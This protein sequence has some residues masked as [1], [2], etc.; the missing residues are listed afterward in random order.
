MTQGRKKVIGVIGASACSQDAVTIAERVGEEIAGRGALLV[1]GGRGGVM[2]AACRGAKNRGGTT[3]GI[4]PDS[5]SGTAN[6]YVDI[7]I[8]TGLGEARNS[9][10]VNSADGLIAVSGSYGTLSEIAFALKQGKPVVGI[11]TWDIDEKIEK[12]QDAA[13]AVNLIFERIVSAN[14]SRS[15]NHGR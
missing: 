15:S 3:I 12:A 14:Q 6:D 2:E 8:A 1:C 5:M 4:L 10:I 11:S 9:V 13:E 7:A